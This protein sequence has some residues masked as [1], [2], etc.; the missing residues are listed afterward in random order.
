MRGTEFHFFS[1][2]SDCL[3]FTVTL[4][5]SQGLI[6]DHH[7]ELEN[8]IYSNGHISDFLQITEIISSLNKFH[9]IRCYPFFSWNFQYV[10]VLLD[11]AF[12]TFGTNSMTSANIDAKSE[13][14]HRRWSYKL[15]CVILTTTS[16]DKRK[17]NCSNWRQFHLM[18]VLAPFV[19]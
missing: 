14:R 8:H 9:E 4:C 6:G 12:L 3:S 16:D 17:K 13:E 11:S 18:A 5:K 1:C 10:V 15:E 19:P 2:P 7:H